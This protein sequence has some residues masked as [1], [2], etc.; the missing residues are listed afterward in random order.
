MTP[1]QLLGGM[2]KRVREEVN[3]CES[4]LSCKHLPLSSYDSKLVPGLETTHRKATEEDDATS[5]PTRED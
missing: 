5:K 1:V 2:Q 4:G 3:R